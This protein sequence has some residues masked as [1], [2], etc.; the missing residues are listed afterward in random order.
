MSNIR[1]ITFW[2]AFVCLA[3]T[4][5]YTI[6]D[7]KNFIAVT[8]TLN[9]LIITNL[10]WLFNLS[11]V[12]LVGIVVYAFFSPISRVRIGGEK[13]L[14]MLTPFR[15]FAV[16]LTTV[17]AMGILFWSVAEPILHYYE[18]PKY[19]G[20]TPESAES[21]RFAM[22]TIFVHWTITPYSIYTVAGLAF[23]LSFH[24]LKLKFSIGSMLRPL[25]GRWVD[26]IGGQIIDGL[27]LFSVVLGMSATLT[28][29]LLVIG[30]GLESVLGI[31]KSSVT[32]AAIAIGIIGSAIISAAS[33][34][35]RGIQTLARINTWLYIVGALFIFIVGPTAFIL[36]LGV[37]S[38]GVYLSEFFAKNLVTGASGNDQW[39]GWWTVAFFASWFAWAPLSCLFLGKIARGYT[40]RQFIIVNTLLPSLFGFL[41]FS[42]FSGSSLF[43]DTTRSGIMYDAYNASGFASVIYVLFDQLPG[44]TLISSLFIFACFITF[45]TAADSNTDAIGGLCTKGVD[46]D[47]MKSPLWIKACWGSAIAFVA[48]I[49]AS[50]IGVDAVKMLFNLAGVPGLFIVLGSGFAFLKLARKVQINGQV[51]ELTPDAFDLDDEQTVAFPTA[52]ASPVS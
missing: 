23:A 52:V 24:N 45:I 39:P 34:L 36:S 29:G 18:P 43:F 4:V 41:W 37:E 47:H 51:V 26:G 44:S 11:A 8:S 22:S 19:L 46:A 13:A 27:A 40:V 9:D 16:S 15:W 49:S 12:F 14:P 50:Y 42:I 20:V 33:G 38:L 32:Y 48:W 30:D 35:H 7:E 2:P 21:M 28:S 17:I 5:V 25:L 10:S 3:L 1:L 31:E 6:I